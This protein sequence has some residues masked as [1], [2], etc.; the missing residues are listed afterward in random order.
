M[1]L[2]FDKAWFETMLAARALDW[3]ALAAAAG[4]DAETMARIIRDERDVAPPEV[5]AFAALLDASPEEVARRCGV[6]T[7]AP[8]AAA[9]KVEKAALAA[10]EA[11]LDRIEAKLDQVLAAL[12]RG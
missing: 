7:R 1:A 9:E 3:G 11:R 2:F 4:L 5:T 10:L 6:T 12:K 8:V